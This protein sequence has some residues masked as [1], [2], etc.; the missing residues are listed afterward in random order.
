MRVLV[1][2]DDDVTAEML[3]HALGEFGYEVEIA[4]NGREA[5]RQIRTG[6][7]RL[8]VSDWE[9]PE[10]TG[11]ELCRQ[12]RK[13]RFGGYV[14][15]ILLTSR[16]GTRNV[17]E[18]LNA[19]AD[20]FISKPF[21]PEEL[22]V[23]LRAGERILSLQSRD[24][25]IFAMAKLAESRD[26]ETG[27]HLERIREYS[28]VLAEQLSRRTELRDQLDDEYI[29][30][31]YLTSPLHDI[32]KVGIPD[33]VLLKPGRLTADE[34]E[35]MKR[36]TAIGGETLEAVGRAHPGAQ[37]LQ[38]ACDIAWSHHEK[39]DGSGYPRGLAGEEIPLC[40][41]IVAL[42]DVY[43]ALTT[44]RV[45]KPAYSHETAREIILEGTDTQFDPA[46]VEAFLQRES[47]F[48]TIRQQFADGEEPREEPSTT[49][50]AI[51]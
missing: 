50:P 4:R 5:F 13:R 34:F 40:S 12:I 18:G 43:D 35:V 51:C 33:R 2:E 3:E 22:C 10:M 17:V 30:T 28:R 47:Q 24:L 44:K 29:Q 26:P 41:R 8:V 16:S 1:V 19:G 7:Y 39:F 38:M 36:H 32:G 6:R 27:A 14:Y 45:Y 42:A 37:F 25:T 9:M 20:D 49:S 31:L 48:L 21:Q 11:V 15:V 46:M 23:R